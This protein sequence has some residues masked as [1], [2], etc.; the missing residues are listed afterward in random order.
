MQKICIVIPCYN[1][2]K[3]LN[4][5]AYVQFISSDNNKNIDFCFVNDG[6]RDN[7]LKVLNDLSAK[8]E[9]ERIK[10]IDLESNRGKAEAVRIGILE[11]DKR[12]K[13]DFVGFWDAD[14]S[15]PLFEIQNMLSKTEDKKIV[16]GSRMKR[17]GAN[18]ERNSKRH[19]LG[20]VFSTF[21]SMILKLPVYDTQ[22]GAKLFHTSIIN[23]IFK[24]TFITKWLFDVELLARYR[25][26][27]GVKTLL[28]SVYEYPLNEWVE[29]KGSKLKWS[30][31]I[32][33][34][35]ELCKINKEYN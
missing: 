29:V 17:L 20:R 6:S 31:F 25:N 24:S 1:E 4:I 11:A 34:P 23:E 30:D 14:L 26:F 3:R 15:T 18:I 22:C 7:T 9:L 8:F 28:G 12:K 19:L 2:E 33:V 5:D 32:K 13:Y 27:V 35:L 16:I 21:S 10:V